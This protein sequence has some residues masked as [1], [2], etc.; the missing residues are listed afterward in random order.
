MGGGRPPLFAWLGPASASACFV[1]THELLSA[2]NSLPHTST[3]PTLP[4]APLPLLTSHLS[5]PPVRLRPGR[6]P[7][8]LLA[9]PL[10]GAQHLWGGERPGPGA[11]GARHRWGA[12]G[13]RR[14]GPAGPGWGPAGATGDRGRQ[15]RQGPVGAGRGPTG[16]DGRFS[17]ACVCL[18]KKGRRELAGPWRPHLGAGGE[19]RGQEGW[20][21]GHGRARPRPGRRGLNPSSP[22]PSLHG[23]LLTHSCPA[24][25]SQGSAA[26]ACRCWSQLRPQV[27][28]PLLALPPAPHSLPPNRQSPAQAS[29]TAACRW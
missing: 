24:W 16:A 23:R 19:S 6:Q 7:R 4:S 14:Q 22:A 12:A 25:F 26:A 8:L 27:A 29:A 2:R 17:A 5:G 9:L 28:L 21:T 10:A 15:R 20:G 1:E 11:P 3:P 13:H 18:R